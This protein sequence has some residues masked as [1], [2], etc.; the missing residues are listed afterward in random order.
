MGCQ[1]VCVLL[2][3]CFY[4]QPIQTSVFRMCEM[5]GHYN[6]FIFMDSPCSGPI[7]LVSGFLICSDLVVPDYEFSEF[8]G[9]DIS[10]LFY[11]L[12]SMVKISKFAL[13]DFRNVLNR[14]F[15]TW[16]MWRFRFYGVGGLVFCWCRLVRMCRVMQLFLCICS[17]N[18]F[19]EF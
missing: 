17:Q 3:L 7:F 5:L 2:I 4:N 12:A 15:G 13:S 10:A 6:L 11:F 1:D 9:P 16:G 18:D 8:W 14:E 19:Y